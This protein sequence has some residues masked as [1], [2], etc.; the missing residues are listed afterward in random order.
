MSI[1]PTAI[2]IERPSR[3]GITTLKA[4]IATPTTMIVMVWPTPQIAPTSAA[5]LMVSMARDNGADRY[6]MIR[7]AMIRIAGVPHTEHETER[8]YR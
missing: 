8:D 6:H 7:I 4:M 2:S 5:P 3:A 1:R